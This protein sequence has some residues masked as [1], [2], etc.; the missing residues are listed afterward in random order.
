MIVLYFFPLGRDRALF[1]P[2][3]VTVLHFFPLKRDRALFFALE[4]DRA[5]LFA[6]GT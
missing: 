4:R 3:N 5:R 1:F 2:W 6:P